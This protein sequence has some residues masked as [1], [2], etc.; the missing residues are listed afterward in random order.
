LVG[1]RFPLPE[2]VDWT[3]PRAAVTVRSALLAAGSVPTLATAT[4]TPAPVSAASAS[5]SATRACIRRDRTTGQLGVVLVGAGRGVPGA[6]PGP[7]AGGVTPHFA[8]AARSFANCA[9]SRPAPPLGG[10]VA[11]AGGAVA[12]PPPARPAPGPGSVTPACFRHAWTFGS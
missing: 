2:T 3:T 11:P 12:V 5:G 8:S 7:R 10:A 1:E 9:G 4:A 6:P